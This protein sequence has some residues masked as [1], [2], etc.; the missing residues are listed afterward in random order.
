MDL[1]REAL[2]VLLLDDVIVYSLFIIG[3][4]V[5]YIN[6]CKKRGFYERKTSIDCH[7]RIQCF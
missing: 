1:K 3:S 2:L 7:S 6:I 5:F 4:G